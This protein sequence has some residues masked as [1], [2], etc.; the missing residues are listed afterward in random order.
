MGREGA[1][2]HLGQMQCGAVRLLRDLLAAAEPV[3]HDQRGGTRL[4]DRGQ[5]YS[6]AARDRHFVVVA[7]LEAERAGHAA[8]PRYRCVYVEAEL[9]QGRFFT[10]EIEHRFVMAMP[11]HQ[12]LA[13][14]LGP[15]EVWGMVDE[16]FA[17]RLR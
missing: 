15:G 2:E 10:G 11:V 5:Q 13:V 12:R 4:P 17:Q 14:E 7:R 3:G 16:K 6:L 9:Q 8:A 1:L